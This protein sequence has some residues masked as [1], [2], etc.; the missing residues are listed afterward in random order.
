MKKEN[1]VP[2]DGGV[3]GKKKERGDKVIAST[4][5]QS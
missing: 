4:R 3:K 2:A 1:G 5:F